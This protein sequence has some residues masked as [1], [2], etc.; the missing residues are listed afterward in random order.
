MNVN[1]YIKLHWLYIIKLWF[2]WWI[3]CPREKWIL[4]WHPHTVQQSA[5]AFAAPAPS[6][7]SCAFSNEHFYSIIIPCARCLI[8]V[9]LSFCGTL[10]SEQPN[11]K[12]ST[13]WKFQHAIF[14]I[15]IL[16]EEKKR[17][18][19]VK[20]LAFNQLNVIWIQYGLIIRSLSHS[21]IWIQFVIIKR[22]MHVSL[23]SHSKRVSK[24]NRKSH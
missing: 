1:V 3:I 16:Y 8:V 21:I 4:P 9:L 19:I 15:R 24:W 6:F 11:L 13:P 10:P 18:I 23:L 17:I 12:L 7:S 20:A 22:L 2:N 14:Y 5:F